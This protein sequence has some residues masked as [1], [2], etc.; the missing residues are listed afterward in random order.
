MAWF[1]KKEDPKPQPKP[2]AAVGAVEGKVELPPLARALDAN[3]RAF[4][5]TCCD[6]GTQGIVTWPDLGVIRRVSFYRVDGDQLHLTVTNDG[7]TP[8]DCKP[9]T[10]CVVS[11]FY[12][13]RAACFIAYEESKGAGQRAELVV[14]RMPT[15]IA[16]EGR[17]RFRIPILPKLELKVALIHDNRR[18]RV[19]ESIDISVAGMML[20]FP[21]EI[22][23]GLAA[24]QGTQVEL[25]LEGDSYRV[26]CTIR[27]RI[28]RTTDVRYG[29]LFHNGSNGFDYEHDTEL[30]DMIM[31]IER[32]YVRNRNR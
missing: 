31:G 26:P 8:Y 24:E 4:L 3:E 2:T 21:R 13:D 20:A 27:N 6:S 19:P 11:F 29:I 1:T 25:T 23:P 9:R 10:Q 17:T 12:R 16:V 28:V 22:D 14:L 5:V 18:I 30:N 15:Q 7:G 32:F